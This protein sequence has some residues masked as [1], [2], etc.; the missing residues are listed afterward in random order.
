ML[1]KILQ[2][3]ERKDIMAEKQLIQKQ[4]PENADI[5]E[6]IYDFM[7]QKSWVFISADLFGRL[8]EKYAWKFAKN[9]DRCHFFVDK[10][11]KQ[12]KVTVNTDGRWNKVE[13]IAVINCQKSSDF[14]QYYTSDPE[15]IV[16]LE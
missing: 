1:L 6:E 5:L 13:I 8:K 3:Q 12:W 16:F 7:N 10:H 15:K 4:L 14:E 2:V 11:R 9:S